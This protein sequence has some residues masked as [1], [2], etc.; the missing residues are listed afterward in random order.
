MLIGLSALAALLANPVRAA[1]THAE[2]T[3]AAQHANL[4]AGAAD[5]AG[6]RMHL[7][8]AVNCIEGPAGADFAPKELN[9]CQNAGT[10]AIPDAKDPNAITALRK[11]DATALQG[12]AA[13][14][15]KS[16]Q[17][18]ASAAAAQLGGIH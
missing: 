15:L 5:L 13:A 6:V 10:G 7:H 2:I 11:A 3:I 1:D 9:P 12:L 4:A 14:D 16:A 8:H 17:S 18:D